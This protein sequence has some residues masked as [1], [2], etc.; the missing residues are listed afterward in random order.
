RLA[1]L[2]QV[3]EKMYEKMQEVGRSI[4]GAKKSISTWAKS[5]GLAHAK[6]HQYGG[7]GG[8]PCGFGVANAV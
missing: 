2:A 4:K 3:W 1:S 8:A 7:G 6:M 5:K